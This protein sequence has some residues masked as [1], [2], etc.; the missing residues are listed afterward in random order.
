MFTESSPQTGQGSLDEKFD[1]V[2]MPYLTSRQS[3]KRFIRTTWRCRG[4]HASQAAQGCA[5][6]TTGLS[7]GHT[8]GLRARFT[9]TTA[10][11]FVPPRWY[12]LDLIRCRARF[13][14]RHPYQKSR[15]SFRQ[16]GR[17]CE[18]VE[19]DPHRVTV[20]D[21]SLL[22]LGAAHVS[23]CRRIRAHDWGLRRGRMAMTKTRSKDGGTYE[24]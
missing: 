24:R 11:S 22:R 8:R 12:A 20:A 16:R 2:P 23:A 3:R 9:I 6:R 15:H 18:D 10:S 7:Q 21:A 13:E 14:N 17:G 1:T 19:L 5:A 4:R